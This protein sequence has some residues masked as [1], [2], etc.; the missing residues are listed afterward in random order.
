MRYFSPMHRGFVDMKTRSRMASALFPKEQE[1]ARSKITILMHFFFF[2]F[3][4]II[5]QKKLSSMNEQKLLS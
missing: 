5:K 2:S 4:I 3:L 1:W